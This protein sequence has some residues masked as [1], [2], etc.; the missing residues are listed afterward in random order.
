MGILDTIILMIT[1]NNKQINTQEI[2]DLKNRIDEL[3][4]NVKRL[5]EVAYNAVAEIQTLKN[6]TVKK[7]SDPIVW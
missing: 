1:G 5:S 4:L 3:E 6:T 2:N 7:Q